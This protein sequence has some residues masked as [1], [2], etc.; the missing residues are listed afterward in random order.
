M[1]S[2]HPLEAG[3]HT[4]EDDPSRLAH[5]RMDLRGTVVDVL[6]VYVP[7]GSGDMARKRAVLRSL[8]E[9]SSRILP[10]ATPTVLAGDMNCD[11]LDD[12]GAL[13]PSLVGMPEFA[14]L[15]DAGW[16]DAHRAVVERGRSATWW[17]NTSRRGFR[18]DHVLTAGPLHPVASRSVVA[19]G[20]HRLV[21]CP[22]PTDRADAPLSDHA[23]LVTDLDVGIQMTVW[24]G[25]EVAS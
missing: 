5:A 16:H 17:H 7:S 4:I 11:H 20:S 6:G 3:E 12:T 2:R 19:A 1:A 10:A 22:T 18:I 25:A 9:L 13:D 15:V 14:A 24:D 8:T 21:N 23:A